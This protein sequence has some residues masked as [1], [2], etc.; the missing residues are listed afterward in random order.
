MPYQIVPKQDFGHYGYYDA[1]RRCLIRE[2]FIVTD[3]FCNVMP[4]AT[5]FRT[6]E[7]AEIGIEALRLAGDNADFYAVYKALKKQRD[8]IQNMMGGV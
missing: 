8:E 6:K 5:W 1:K 3:G 4:G 2:G 7:E